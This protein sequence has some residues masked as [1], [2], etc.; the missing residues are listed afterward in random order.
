MVYPLLVAVSDVE[1]E[2]EV[3]PAR[4]IS[5]RSALSEVGALPTV[6]LTS[7]PIAPSVGG[8]VL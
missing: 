5:I 7:G 8:R 2:P 3:P 1:I 4:A 6:V